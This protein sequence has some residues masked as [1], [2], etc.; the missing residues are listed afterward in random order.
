MRTILLHLDVPATVECIEV[1]TAALVVLNQH[2]LRAQPQLPWL[3]RS[4]VH[5]VR[6]P[7]TRALERWCT[8]PDVLRWPVVRDCKNL[9]AWRVAELRERARVRAVTRVHEVRPGI[10]HVDVEWPDGTLEDPSKVL[11]MKSSG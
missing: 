11:G 8:I 4:G 6:T 9:A 5:Y 1:A 3:Y 7:Q 10:F 2:V